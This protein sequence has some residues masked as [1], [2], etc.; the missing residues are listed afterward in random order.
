MIIEADY[1]DIT[2]I[3]KGMVNVLDKQLIITSLNR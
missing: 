3:H 1:P 2:I